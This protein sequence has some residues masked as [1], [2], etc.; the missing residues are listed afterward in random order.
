MSLAR[1]VAWN[2]LIQVIGRGLGLVA[3]TAQT[4]II[5]HHLGVATFGQYT[6]AAAFVAIFTVLGES[7]LYL[8]SVRRAS[9]ETVNRSA[10]LGT[11]LGL[12]LLWSLPPLIL[13]VVLA[14]FI[15][16]ERFPTWDVSVKMAVGILALNAYFT[17]FNQ[18]LAGIFRL[19][20][21][22]G[23]AVI[24]ELGARLVALVAV[25]WVVS[26]GG[27]LQAVLT[28]VLL[29][30]TTNSVYAFL[31]TRRLEPFRIQ[32]D[33][34]LAGE[35]LRE[36]M[37]LAVVI[38]LGL[39]RQ[40]IDA[41][42]LTAL[43]TQ[44]DVGIYGAALRVHEVLITF[45]ALF[46]ALLYPVFSRLASQGLHAVQPVFQRTFDVLLHAGLCAALALW[47]ASPALAA[48]LGS[49]QSDAPIRLLA[50]ALPGAFIGLGFSHLVYAEGRNGVVVRLYAFL[51]VFNLAANLLL[52]PR[53][54]YNGA[55]LSAVCTEWVSM[56]ILAFYWIGMRRMRLS[57]RGLA[58]LPVCL[59]LALILQPLR[60]T[61]LPAVDAGVVSQVVALLVSGSVTAL[62]YVVSV[63]SLR[64]LPLQV[65]RA[66][67]PTLSRPQED[68]DRADNGDAS[69]P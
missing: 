64:L 28:A 63:M 67:L 45:P 5:I 4:A 53:F 65:L 19:H 41:L 15:S 37:P 66:V 60:N 56:G 1:A 51:V 17:L 69:R 57:R 59:V 35:L 7:G 20:L 23:L 34:R 38:I 18:Y 3:S 36:A 48:T 39:L 2:T 22:M 52:I 49:P 25:L 54:A 55:A 26:V 14:Q 29:G 68:G 44:T 27:S 33:R 42:L 47:I 8:V 30:T 32:L 43:A 12:R 9:Q 21:R 62:L 13:A 16:S 11:A 40:K 24:G 46:V 50:L 61:W 31:V 6:S 58:A 10:I